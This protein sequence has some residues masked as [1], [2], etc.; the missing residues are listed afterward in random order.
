MFIPIQII[1][2]RAN[3]T[4]VFQRITWWRGL[5]DFNVHFN[6]Q[7]DVS[8]KYKFPNNCQFK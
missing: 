5:R 4:T 7:Q 8:V 1:R 2:S 3:G 6:F